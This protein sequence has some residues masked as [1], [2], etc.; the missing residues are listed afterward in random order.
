[1]TTLFNTLPLVLENI[2]TD[3]KKQMEDIE[4]QEYKEQLFKIGCELY[5]EEFEDYS[6]EDAECDY[7]NKKWKE[8]DKKLYYDVY[9]QYAG[10]GNELCI[11]CFCKIFHCFIDYNKKNI[12]QTCKDINLLCK[13]KYHKGI[14]NK[15][16]L[17]PQKS[18]YPIN[19]FW[20]YV[21][22]YIRDYA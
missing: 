5:F 14:K 6:F 11:D 16:Y 13:N 20:T 18:G 17:T 2:I 21:S 10:A 19:D 3:Y 9:A 12:K 22:R 15:Y 1:M 7:C 4:I 8:Q